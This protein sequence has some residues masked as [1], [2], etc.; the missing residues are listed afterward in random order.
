MP[1]GT[2]LFDTLFLYENFPVDPTPSTIAAGTASGTDGTSDD[3]GSRFAGNQA[4]V[5]IPTTFPLVLQVDPSRTQIGVE[6]VVDP[7]A[8]PPDRAQEILDTFQSV[9]ER[10]TTAPEG[11]VGGWIEFLVSTAREKLSEER[12]RTRERNRGRLRRLQRN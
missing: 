4:S 1:A 10:M 6:A 7:T 9:V 12:L 5:V 3:A 8:I 2:P 11:E